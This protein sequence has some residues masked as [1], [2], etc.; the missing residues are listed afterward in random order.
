M[1][2][3]YFNSS[4]S[5]E[6]Y[7]IIK[8]EAYNLNITIREHISNIVSEYAKLKRKEAE[9]EAEVSKKEEA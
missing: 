6:D 3:T 4:V 9:H 8:A 7:A 1:S 5:R 2:N